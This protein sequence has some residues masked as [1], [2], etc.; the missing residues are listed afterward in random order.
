MKISNKI[1]LAFLA[2]FVVIG[3]FSIALQKPQQALGSVDNDSSG[4]RSTTTPYASGVVLLKGTSTTAT[5]AVPGTPN[6]PGILGS[7]FVTGG[8]K[9][10][11][12]AFYDSTTSDPALRAS[13]LATSTITLFE[14]P[15]GTGST[16]YSGIDITFT[17]GLLMVT[18]GGAPATTTCTWK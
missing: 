12:I 2:V 3:F 8:P 10:G 9:G 13:T 1:F 5:G 14:I 15:T 6:S 4:Y 16:S 17:R 18:S 11:A 7:C